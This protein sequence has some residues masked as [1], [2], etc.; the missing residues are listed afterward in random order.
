MNKCLIVYLLLLSAFVSHAQNRGD[1]VN[2]VFSDGYGSTWFGTDYGLLRKTGNTW[3][4]YFTKD[5]EPGYVNSLTNQQTTPD[6]TLWIG[7]MKGVTKAT[8]NAAGILS[9]VPYHKGNTLLQSDTVNNIAVSQFNTCF[10]ATPAG[11]G[12]LLDNVWSFIKTIGDVSSA[13]FKSAKAMGDTIYIATHGKGVARLVQKVDGFT[14]ASSYVKP[15]SALPSDDVNCVFIDSKRNQWY[16]TSEGLARHTSIKA[17]EGWDIYL[18]SEL[19]NPHINA[20]AED[21][22]SNIWIGTPGGLTKL[23]IDS[24]HITITNYTSTE[25]LPD[26]HI[27]S[28]YVLGNNSIWIGTD[29]GA[30]YYDGTKFENVLTSAYARDFEAASGIR[31][32]ET[33]GNIIYTVYPNPVTS[34]LNITFNKALS[35]PTVAQIY[36]LSGKQLKNWIIDKNQSECYKDLNTDSGRKLVP[37][38]YLLVIQ[39]DSIEQATKIVVQ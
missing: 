23:E 39:T 21:P 38:I 10:F 6:N 35:K 34:G 16:G 3:K 29:K 2:A 8:Y 32:H 31:D 7:T 12:I 17:K 15:W 20:I 19:P 33:A 13:E 28:I 24:T 25:G 4:A 27:N 30:S 5:S 36:T 9:A 14:G 22:D 11:L 26:N 37:G 1:T 18:T